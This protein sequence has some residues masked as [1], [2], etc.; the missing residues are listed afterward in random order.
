M[1]ARLHRDRLAQLNVSASLRQGLETLLS[2]LRETLRDELEA[3]CIF[4]SAARGEWDERYSDLNLLLVLTEIDFEKLDTIARAMNQARRRHRI[5]PLIL[6]SKELYQSADVFCI[7]FDDIQRH[8]VT[9]VGDD[10]L[11]NLHIDNRE[12]RF[13]CEFDLRNLALRMRMFFLH[14]YAQRPME[15]DVLVRF[16]ASSIFPLRTL[17][18]LMGYPKPA[19][20]PEAIE[21]I[22][23]ALDTEALVLRELLEVHRNHRELSRQ[24][25]TRLYNAFNELV[26][27][28]VQ[29][30]DQLEPQE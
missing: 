20:T 16:F 8:H 3:A 7:K 18:G 17:A 19:S 10:P 2:T 21:V 28:A 5:I 30:V 14:N 13:V 24:D 26:A 27:L 11:D 22:G 15:Q 1:P 25:V 9:L 6:T 12:L 23:R 29:K 4:G